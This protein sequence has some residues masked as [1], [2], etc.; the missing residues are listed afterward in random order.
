MV[1]NSCVAFRQYLKLLLTFWSL[2][3][4]TIGMTLPCSAHL[5]SSSFIIV[6]YSLVNTNFGINKC[7]WDKGLTLPRLASNN[8]VDDDFEFLI[9]TPPFIWSAGIT[10]M[11]LHT[12][13]RFLLLKQVLPLPSPHSSL[14]AY[15]M[16]KADGKEAITRF[17]RSGNS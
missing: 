3:A 16:C 13:L 9:L 5:Y 7:I 17:L 15:S 2:K 8:V 14:V 1:N 6:G 4:G 11:C 12:W 10:A